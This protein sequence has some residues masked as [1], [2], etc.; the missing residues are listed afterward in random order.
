MVAFFFLCVLALGG[1]LLKGLQE[2]HD[3]GRSD[4]PPALPR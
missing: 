1:A 4:A 2:G 3:I